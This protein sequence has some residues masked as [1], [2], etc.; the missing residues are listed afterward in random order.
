VFGGSANDQLAERRIIH[1][2]KIDMADYD[3]GQLP[4]SH[5]QARSVDSGSSSSADRSP[6]PANVGAATMRAST[7]CLNVQQIAGPFDGREVACPR[8]GKEQH[9]MSGLPP[10]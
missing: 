1:L 4:Q 10:I 6:F 5:E 7:N 2:L 3:P 9:A 8:K